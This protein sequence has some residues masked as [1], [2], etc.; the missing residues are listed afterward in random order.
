MSGGELEQLRGA[1]QVRGVRPRAP[2]GP[3][4]SVPFPQRQLTPSCTAVPAAAARRRPLPPLTS[5]PLQLSLTQKLLSAL[6]AAEQVVELLSN[7]ARQAQLEE[8]CARFLSDVQ[9]R[10]KRCW[11]PAECLLA[12]ACAGPPQ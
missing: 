12:D 11:M 5:A 8:L 7:G 4:Q 2:C 6:Q 3:W 10:A 9:V 1:E